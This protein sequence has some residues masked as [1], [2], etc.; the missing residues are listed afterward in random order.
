MEVKLLE[1]KSVIDAETMHK[2]STEKLLMVYNT[3][4]ACNRSW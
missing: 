1:K 4:Q 2:G 3:Y